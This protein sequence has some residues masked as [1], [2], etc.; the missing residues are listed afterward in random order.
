MV[1]GRS[2]LFGS[3]L[4]AKALCHVVDGRH[5]KSLGQGYPRDF[6]LPEAESAV[7]LFAVEVDVLVVV[8]VVVVA[9]ARLVAQR[10][11]SVLDGMY[12]MVL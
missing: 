6:L 9:L 1:R 5:E 3:T 10:A 4:G 2:R 11:A 8:R 7:A 12:G